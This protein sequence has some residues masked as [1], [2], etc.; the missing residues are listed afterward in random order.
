MSAKATH[1]HTITITVTFPF[2]LLSSLFLLPLGTKHTTVGCTYRMLELGIYSIHVPLFYSI[3][4]S[5]CAH[6]GFMYSIDLDTFPSGLPSLL[7]SLLSLL[8]H[9]YPLEQEKSSPV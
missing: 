3:L 8:A 7:P 9:F 5:K 2:P 1:H 4:L 6:A